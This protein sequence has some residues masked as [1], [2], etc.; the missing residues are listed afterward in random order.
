MELRLA[1]ACNALG[2]TDDEAIDIFQDEVDCRFPQINNLTEDIIKIGV[3]KDMINEYVRGGSPS[4]LEDIGMIKDDIDK[5]TFMDLVRTA[6]NDISKD[7]Y[8][9]TLTERR[10]DLF[11]LVRDDKN[12]EKDM[13][14]NIEDIEEVEDIKSDFSSNEEEDIDDM[15]WGD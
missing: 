12:T 11:N 5:T 7:P 3:M 1:D 2:L 9:E 8:M 4:A 6:Q 15:E 13:R 14:Q 10:D